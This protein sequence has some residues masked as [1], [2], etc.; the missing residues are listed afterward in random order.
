LA[1]DP[2]LSRLTTGL[3]LSDAV[4]SFRSPDA[5]LPLAP[6][7]YRS[8]TVRERGERAGRPRIY[9]T[10]GTIFNSGSGD[11]FERLLA[12][13][14]GLGADVVATIGKRMDPA[15]LGPQPAHVRVERFVPQDEVLPDVD[16]VV[17]HG[18]SGSLMATLAHGLPS[19]LLPLGADQ[20][21][22]ALR[23]EELGVAA[24]ID[25]AA[26]TAEEIGGHART[27]LADD[28]M[29]DRCRAVA[30]EVRELPGPAAAVA[31]LEAVAGG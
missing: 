31:A 29:R 18:G 30:A 10:L 7:H 15:D 1:P 11:L 21:H 5:P 8:A 22:N 12:G 27:V 16:L 24:A 25:A 14:A 20:P 28:A 23:A 17:S 6:T 2:D 3:V 13:L 9:V 26:V 19:L 4:P